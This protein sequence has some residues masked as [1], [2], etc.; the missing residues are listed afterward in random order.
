M[1]SKKLWKTGL[2]MALMGSAMAA[3]AQ[4]TAKGYVYED[5]NGNG[6]K[7]S[8][9]Q[10]LAGV[11]ICNGHQI[12][13]TKADGSYRIPV[14]SD[15]VIFVIK[16]AGYASPLSKDNTPLSYFVYKPKGAPDGLKYPGSKPTELPSDLNFALQKVEEPKD[17]SVLLFGDPQPYNKQELAYFK[18]SIVDVLPH[19]AAR[20][21][22]GLSL[23]DLVGND[24]SLHP[25]YKSTVAA[26]GI[27][28][29][30]VIGNHDMNQD[31]LSDSLSDETFEMNFGPANYSMNMANTHFIVLDDIL[32]PDPR[33]NKGYWGGLREDQFAF[34]E[35]DLKLV[36]PSKLI[37]VAF[38]IP[39]QDETGA[40]F[41]LKDKQ[42]IFDLLE[43]Y[44]NCLL[45]SA[46]THYQQQIF[47]T[48]K[49]GWHGNTPLHEYN[50][51]TTSGDWYSGVLVNGIP[52]RTMRDGTPPGYADLNIKN[53]QYELAYHPV[54]QHT[55]VQIGIYAPKLVPQGKRSSA[56][57]YANF[58]M[59]SQQD[60]VVCRI[61]QGKWK[62]MTW[63]ETIDPN[64][65]KT[66]I[67]WDDSKVLMNGRRPS[68]ATRSTH[69]WTLAVPAKLAEGEHTI[70]VKATDMYGHAYT[71]KSTYRI[72]KRP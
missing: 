12:V 43:K 33:D 1:L 62:P 53:N 3:V 13:Q 29:Y 49:S 26:L 48:K 42:R 22:F 51:G 5:K 4:S 46:H 67:K 69:L 10:G 36:D 39:L 34:L 21:Q 71:N 27:P 28:W 20:Y 41:R 58:Y 35:N 32:F 14:A 61:D 19:P 7:D 59:G 68:R 23:G 52:D 47:Y 44:P 57:I 63:L 40:A 45:L 56:A 66:L 64:Y 31:V 55:G 15:N 37:V 38:H 6:K 9:E 8:Q 17:F 18:K 24:L 70:E 60:K 30:N 54:G 72:K 2:C 25:A 16:P 11:G 50:V 65:F